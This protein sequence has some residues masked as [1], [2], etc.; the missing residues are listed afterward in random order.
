MT[1][2]YD[3]FDAGYAARR[4]NVRLKDC[5]HNDATQDDYRAGWMG[6]AADWKHGWRTANQE[7]AQQP[8]LFAG[9]G[10]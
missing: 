2:T 3:A 7:L 10:Q 8:D 5:P 6:L 4:N 9:A 1:K